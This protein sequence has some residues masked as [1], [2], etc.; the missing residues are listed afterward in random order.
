[1]EVEGGF[2]CG[3]HCGS[4]GVFERMNKSGHRKVEW[5]RRHRDSSFIAI[6]LLSTHRINFMNHHADPLKVFAFH[7]PRGILRYGGPPKCARA[8]RRMRPSLRGTAGSLIRPK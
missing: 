5:H 4:G 7:S 1:V 6:A 8:D 2:H 3:P